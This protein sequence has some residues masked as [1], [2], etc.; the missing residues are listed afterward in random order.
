[1]LCLPLSTWLANLKSKPGV[2]S[3]APTPAALEGTSEG[4]Y[5]QLASETCSLGNIFFFLAPP[6][7]ICYEMPLHM[8]KSEKC[9]KEHIHIFTAQIPTLSSHFSIVKYTQHIIAHSHQFRACTS[10]A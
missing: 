10:V 4:Y 1:M 7:I 2:N 8:N 3:S 9:Y 6:T 5:S